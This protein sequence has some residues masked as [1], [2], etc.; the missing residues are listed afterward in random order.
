MIKLALTILILSV[1]LLGSKKD[2][3]DQSDKTLNLLKNPGAENNKAAMTAST[4][5]HLTVT[6]TDPI[7]G[8]ASFVYDAAAA[9]DT[10][11]TLEY[12]VPIELR[13][14]PCVVAFRYIS[15]SLTSGHITYRVEDDAD[16]PLF[17]AVGMEPTVGGVVTEVRKSFTCP[18]D[19]VQIV[20][21][22]TA[23]AAAVKIDSIS[24]GS[25]RVMVPEDVTSRCLTG[26]VCS[27]VYT[28]VGTPITNVSAVTEYE[29]TYMKV[30]RALVVQIAI[31][32]NISG[33]GLWRINLTLPYELNTTT[34]T[35]CSGSL[36]SFSA[37]VRGAIVQLETTGSPSKLDI[38]GNNEGVGVTP[39][40]TG[41]VICYD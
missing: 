37:D 21:E 12:D 39:G 13:G 9:S 20:W 38:R 40:M 5:A 23:D 27:G 35:R 30:G 10:L 32:P 26:N 2:V 8:V 29:M 25:D 16:T 33:S 31:A 11:S 24:L 6:T 28:P 18:V 1:S 22:A 19:K 41:I 34:N 3:Q 17:S 14:R 4:P 7:R 36:N 15:D